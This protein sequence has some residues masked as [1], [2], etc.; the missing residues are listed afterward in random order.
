[1]YC[2][3]LPK[4]PCEVFSPSEF[5]FGVTSGHCAVFLADWQSDTTLFSPCQRSDK[6]IHVVGVAIARQTLRL[7][8]VPL[9]E[10]WIVGDEGGFHHS[11]E[12][13]SFCPQSTRKVEGSERA[14]RDRTWCMSTR[15]PS[16][17]T[18]MLGIAKSE[19]AGSRRQPCFK[20][21]R[22]PRKNVQSQQF[23]S[24]VVARVRCLSLS[25][26]CPVR[27][28]AVEASVSF[29]TKTSCACCKIKV[30]NSLCVIRHH[31]VQ[32][33]KQMSKVFFG[34]QHTITDFASK[35][36]RC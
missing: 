22:H 32:A 19:L 36:C 5:T 8:G 29:T 2:T 21:A 23:G 20:V 11:L 16:L 18:S 6:A 4:I 10:C 33:S 34:T 30:E 9:Q 1:M 13:V 26:R 12:S 25:T 35:V 28:T 7:L 31:C 15:F 27:S 14:L 17:A 3:S 24:R